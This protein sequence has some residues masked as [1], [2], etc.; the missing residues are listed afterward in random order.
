MTTKTGFVVN[1]TPDGRI[2]AQLG[3]QEYTED[4]SLGKI[5]S[6]IIFMLQII[7]QLKEKQLTRLKKR[8]KIAT[9]SYPTEIFDEKMM[10]SF[11]LAMGNNFTQPKAIAAIREM[12]IG[13]VDTARYWIKA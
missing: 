10:G 1:F 5:E 4:K 6:M 3:Y 2:A 13:I 12:G 9:R 8:V 7:P 11:C